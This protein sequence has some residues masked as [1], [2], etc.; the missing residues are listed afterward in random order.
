VKGNSYGYWL[1][2]VME[3][4]G[5]EATPVVGISYGG[6]LLQKLI[7]AHPEKVGKAIFTVP[8]GGGKQ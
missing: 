7:M 2:E 1:G 3:G 8:G 6:F 4:L 5:L